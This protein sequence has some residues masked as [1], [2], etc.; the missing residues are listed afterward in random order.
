MR[1]FPIRSPTATDAASCSPQ[2]QMFSCSGGDTDCAIVQTSPSAAIPSFPC[3]LTSGMHPA[4]HADPAAL[5]D[6]AGP[7][8]HK[9]KVYW[10]NVEPTV[11]GMLGGFS[12]VSPTDISESRKFL[13]QFFRPRKSA[14]SAPSAAGDVPRAQSALDCGAGI[15]RITKLLLLSFS[16]EVHLLEQSQLFLDKS[17]EYIG[18]ESRH[19]VKRI[20][21]S[22]Q[23]FQP[24]PGASY[25]IIW[26]QWV[27]GYLTDEELITFLVK[28][29]SCL[30]PKHGLIILKDNTTAGSEPDTDMNDS[31]VTRAKHALVHII[32]AANLHIREERRQK[33]MP[34]GLYPV[35]MFA[36]SPTPTEQP[37]R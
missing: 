2:Q 25:D 4:D 27:T 21:A 1:S 16:D 32:K 18:P 34:R 9:S 31:S 30:D 14:A 11:S 6:A 5:P 3:V 12:R 37:I 29:T 22:L 33:K 24:E 19:R 23:S 20:C 36:L 28:M 17:V 26:L 8:A 13:S 15:G 10:E 35:H 7:D